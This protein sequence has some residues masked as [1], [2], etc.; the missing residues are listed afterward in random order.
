MLVGFIDNGTRVGEVGSLQNSFLLRGSLTLDDTLEN[1][2]EEV[3]KIF[4]LRITLR[5][6]MRRD[7]Q[8]GA[9][10]EQVVADELEQLIV[11][12]NS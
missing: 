12:A 6:E 4:F 2:I 5:G 9:S 1:A 8:A 10:S 7:G 11:V 3:G